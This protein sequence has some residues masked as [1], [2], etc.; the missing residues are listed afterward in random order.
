MSME[1]SPAGGINWLT[2]RALALTRRYMPAPYLFALILTFLAAILA[3]AITPTRLPA[4]A[5]YWYNGIW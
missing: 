4:L 5:G 3:L 2:E 1:R